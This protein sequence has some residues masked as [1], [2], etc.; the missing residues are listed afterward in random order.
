M[1]YCVYK[2][3]KQMSQKTG[4][5]QM[6]KQETHVVRLSDMEPG[7]KIPEGATVI[8]DE[9]VREMERLLKIENSANTTKLSFAGLDMSTCIYGVRFDHFV[10]SNNPQLEFKIDTIKFMKILA[11]TP[12]SDLRAAWNAIQ[13]CVS[14]YREYFG[15]SEICRPE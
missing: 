1:L 9:G 4:G 14:Y 15:V 6:D 10:E 11:K 13:E 12:D 7:T 2:V 3:N 5:E 8:N